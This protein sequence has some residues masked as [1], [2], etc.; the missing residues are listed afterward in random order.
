M[1][2]TTPTFAQWVP[3]GLAPADCHYWRAM[4]LST[5][6]SWFL[7]TFRMQ[8]SLET[9]AVGWESTLIDVVEEVGSTRVVAIQII[10][11]CGPSPGS[12]TTGEVSEVWRATQE[13]ASDTGPLVFKLVGQAELTSSFNSPVAVQEVSRALLFRRPED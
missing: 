7:V 10:R 5:T 13:E 1:F 2:I 11:Q 4:Q 6:M 12:W 8:D 9:L 3:P